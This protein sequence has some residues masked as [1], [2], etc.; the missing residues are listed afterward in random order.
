MNPSSISIQSA[1]GSA[2]S[3]DGGRW[4]HLPFCRRRRR[5]RL[6][7]FNHSKRCGRDGSGDLLHHIAAAVATFPGWQCGDIDV[8]DLHPTR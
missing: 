6:R 1:D 3:L 2:A 4:D 5:H 7:L 8:V